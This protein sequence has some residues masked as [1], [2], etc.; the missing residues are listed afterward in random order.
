ML[1]LLVVGGGVVLLLIVA[2]IVLAVLCCKLRNCRR[3]G[4][5]LRH[6]VPVSPSEPTAEITTRESTFT[7]EEEEQPVPAPQAPVPAPQAVGTDGV[8]SPLE[9]VSHHVTVTTIRYSFYE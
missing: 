3:G 6:P 7:D 1:Y 4:H 2:M 8:E 9:S 5:N